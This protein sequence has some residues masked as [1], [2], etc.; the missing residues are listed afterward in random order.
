M[1]I[2]IANNVK[3]CVH[4]CNI[5]QNILEFF[6]EISWVTWRAINTNEI[7]REAR[8]L[9]VNTHRLKAGIVRAGVQ[10]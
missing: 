4:G 9:Y 5:F 8:I 3:F 10:V 2:K 7:P 1:K 6:K